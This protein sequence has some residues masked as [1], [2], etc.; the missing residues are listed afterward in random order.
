MNRRSKC[1]LERFLSELARASASG[2]GSIRGTVTVLGDIVNAMPHKPWDAELGIAYHGEN[3]PIYYTGNGI[4][5][6]ESSE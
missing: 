2:Y 3:G 5:T 4:E 1:R 6:D